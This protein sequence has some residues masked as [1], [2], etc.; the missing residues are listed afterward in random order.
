MLP[1]ENK[2]RQG[3]QIKFW[4]DKEGSYCHA[5]LVYGF[6]ITAN[7]SLTYASFFFSLL[8][9]QYSLLLFS[10]NTTQ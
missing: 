5:F 4:P 2:D 10:L 3:T 7:F 9:M 6:S 8:N 1:F